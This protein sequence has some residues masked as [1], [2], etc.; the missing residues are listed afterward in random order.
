MRSTG[1]ARHMKHLYDFV[2]LAARCGKVVLS[3]GSCRL[4]RRMGEITASAV[5][6]WLEDQRDA[7]AFGVSTANGYL[8]AFKSFSN[9]LVDAAEYG[10]T[11]CGLAGRDRAMLYLMAAY[12][13]LR[14]SELASLSEAS[15][16]VGSD[17]P[18]VT[19]EAGY[20]K[21]RREDVV[22]LHPELAVQPGSCSRQLGSGREV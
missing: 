14:A 3:F 5:S 21:H 9:W 4:V 1:N 19:V 10:E 2:M 12:T 18:M 8:I 15:F 11:V 17:L 6:S 7:N 22:P 16:D 20:S 13:G